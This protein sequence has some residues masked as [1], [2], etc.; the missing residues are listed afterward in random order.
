MELSTVEYDPVRT[1]YEV[2]DVE[3][4][5][6]GSFQEQAEYLLRYVIL[7]PSTHNA[8]PWKFA[9]NENGIEIYADYG[10]RLPTADPGNREL[11]MS[12]GAALFNLRVA[13]AHFGFQCHVEYD[14]SGTS[15]VPM[16]M[17]ALSRISPNA[18][19]DPDV[20]SLV[21]AI[22]LR[23]TNRHP[24]LVSRVPRSALDVFH[25]IERGGQSTLFVSADGKLNERVA[26]LV[27]EADRLQL[28]DP[29]FRKDVAEWIRP[30]NTARYDGIQSVNLG[31][32]SMPSMLAPW[33]ARV[34][35][36]GRLRAARDRN[37][38]IDAPALLVVV[39]EDSVPHW[40]ESGEL[41]ERVL[42]T[43]VHEGLQYSYFNMPI[44]VPELRLELR[45][46]L[47]LSAWPQVLLRV[48]YCLTEPTPTPRRPVEDVLF[49]Q[50]IV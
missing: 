37:L 23:H 10:R 25:T 1:P 28:S 41:L 35:D 14:H 26:D 18:E 6:A 21:S 32:K 47:G 4:P 16:V 20:E 45:K 9:V 12:I 7:A 48:G 13:A 38:C 3:F 40:L 19:S 24:F 31:M 5:R 33:A 36:L 27:A 34:L 50:H 8:Q 44:Q 22:P 29:A 17:V 11:I 49:K 42:L 39:S 43:I 30:N 15:D 2:D 46:V